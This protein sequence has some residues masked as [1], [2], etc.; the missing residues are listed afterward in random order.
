MKTLH[1]KLL[2][3]SEAYAKWHNH[4][5]RTYHHFAIFIG[6]AIIVT[7][8]SL[9][10]IK[11]F[12]LSYDEI[13]LRSTN[14]PVSPG[15]SSQHLPDFTTNLLRAVKS[16]RTAAQADKILTLSN[17]IAAAQARKQALIASATSNPQEFLLSALPGDLV[18]KLPLEVSTYLEQEKE[19]RGKITIRHFDPEQETEDWFEYYIDDATTGQRYKLEFAQN[20]P[21]RFLTGDYVKAK[22][23]AL[24]NHLVMASGSDLTSTTVS[25]QIT[26]GPTGE[27]HVL[28]MLINFTNYTNQPATP[29]WVAANIFTN[30]NSTN[31]YYHDDA[32]NLTNFSG[33]VT[34]WITVPYDNTNCASMDEVWGLAA[35]QAAVAQGF[36]LSNYNRKLYVMVGASACGYAGSSYVG[37]NPSRTWTNGYLPD[38]S[39]FPKLLDHELGHAIGM[40]HASSF[41]CGSQAIATSGCTLG[42]YGDVY[43]AMG[44][45]NSFHNNAAHKVQ[46]TWIPAANVKTVTASSGVYTIYPLETLGTNVQVLKLYKPDTRENYYLEYRQPLGFDS[47][48][49][50]TITG[51]I[52]IHTWLS[53]NTKL[54]DTT[55]GDN[56]FSNS[57]L[58]D[59]RSFQ[60]TINGITVTQLSHNST[61][62][63]VQV[64]YGSA[65][66]NKSKPTISISPLT[67]S[68]SGG[69]TLKYSVI[70]TN[71]DTPACS[72]S[73]FT[74]SAASLPSGFT[75]SA[76][77]ITLAAGASG[78]VTLSVTSPI[79]VLDGSY[80]FTANAMDTA[81]SSHS[82][83][84]ASGTYVAF[85][86]LLAPTV[87]ISSPADGSTLAANANITVTS[88]DN[89]RVTKVEIYIDGKL[90]VTDSSAPYT[91]KWQTRKVTVGSHIVMAKAYDAAGN[92]STA[93][94]TVNK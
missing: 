86:D 61:S 94:I 25:A 19:I 30:P 5:K 55:P 58:S 51:G 13:A 60:D 85:T 6:V 88:T 52:G 1:N 74:A 7:L 56:N 42:E 9:T 37:G 38:S 79:G 63:S 14:A 21:D 24:D 91:Y 65:V 8:A 64:T 82:S 33:D 44:S 81:D 48:L 28:A 18:S 75:N 62:A 43:D 26:A 72:G 69:Q 76:S 93:Q 46:Q 16:Y 92:S 70:V 41:S 39:N 35:D 34:N 83:N 4:P 77:N 59:G 90:T 73:T 36:V 23:I 53:G 20:S 67:Q 27:Q 89:V 68:T 54:V 50:T 78:T 80:V 45:W 10:G 3:S 87:V 57:Y 17:V 49:P 11:S 66:C 12:A 47:G 29:A 84:P 71:T 40:W 15:K 2:S 32:F 22:G 31:A